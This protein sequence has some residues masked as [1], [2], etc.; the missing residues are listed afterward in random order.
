MTV[1]E[2]IQGMEREELG[3]L[4]FAVYNKGW[5]DGHQGVDDEGIFSTAL[6][7]MDASLLEELQ[8]EGGKIYKDKAVGA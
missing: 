2:R 8:E 7:D 5:F 1:L 3:K 4:L 6:M